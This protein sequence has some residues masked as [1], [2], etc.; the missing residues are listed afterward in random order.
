MDKVGE[1][2]KGVLCRV[3]ADMVFRRDVRADLT[4]KEVG[5]N[6][7]KIVQR[8]NGDW[9]GGEGRHRRV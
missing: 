9:R 3:C 2:I 4:R 8:L 1:G 7:E 6:R 5:K